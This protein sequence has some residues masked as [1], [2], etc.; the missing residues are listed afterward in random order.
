MTELLCKV[1]IV[2]LRHGDVELGAQAILQALDEVPLVFERMR[3]LDAQLQSDDA[4]GG[5]YAQ[6]LRRRRAP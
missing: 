3:V 2:D 5:H 1:L 4:D 6:Q